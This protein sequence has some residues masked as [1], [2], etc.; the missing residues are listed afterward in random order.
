MSTLFD[1]KIT[2]D[3]SHIDRL[4]HV[5]NVVY[6]AWMQDVAMAHIEQLGLGVDAYL[7]LKH[8]MVAVEHQVQ[9]RKAA[10]AGDEIILRTWLDDINALYLHRQYAFFRAKDQTLLF[11]AQT[12][13]ACV[14]MS[15]GRPKRLS[16]T[17]TNAYQPYQATQTPYDFSVLLCD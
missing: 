9:Y 4:G 5:N 2:V 3:E 6:V 16:P 14:E 7:E 15:T 11:T 12:K 8:A 17:F 13:W 1:L 10:F